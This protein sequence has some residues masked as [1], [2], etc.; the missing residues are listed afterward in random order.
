MK[1]RSW[2][3]MLAM[4]AISLGV[5]MVAGAAVQDSA[6]PQ[7]ASDEAAKAYTVA[8][9]LA[10]GA[11][12][13]QPA[14]L[15]STHGIR[16]HLVVAQD[17]SGTHTSLQAA[18][19]ALPPEDNSAKRTVIG[20]V[21]GSYRGQVCLQ[22][23]SP[24]LLVGLGAKASDVRIVASRYAGGSKRPGVDGGNPCLPDLSASSYG[25]FS[26]ATLAIF[27]ND[28][29]LANLTIENDAMNGVK[30]GVGYPVGAGES[31]GAQAVALMTQGDRI[32]LENVELW[33]HQDT[34]YV[35]AI[36]SGANSVSSYRNTGDR[37][38]LHKS[39]IAGDVDFIFGAGTL[40]VDDSTIV[41]RHGRRT[42]GN[43]GHILAPSTPANTALGILVNNSRLVGEAGLRN[44][45]ISLGRAWDTG[46]PSGAWKAGVSPNGQAVVR[47]S[48]L[49]LHV[50]AWAASTSKRPFATSGEAANRFAEWRNVVHG[51]WSRKT[52]AANDGWAAA[53]GGT[54]GGSDALPEHNYTVHN[55]A[56]LLAALAPG[57]FSR[58]IRVVGRIDQ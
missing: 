9:Y 10:Q 54:Q 22:G 27:S 35:R 13:W 28:V 12:A 40:V 14:N 39:L 52:L 25:T 50:G 23:K 19:D 47:D 57:D 30:D 3:S 43:G 7:L 29:Q 44:G 17:G 58:L 16:P 49:G 26:S 55:R 45:S 2:L 48:T 11:T 37:V 18:L 4:G 20:L 8:S 53:E 51:D 32:Q 41:S 15:A 34:L 6:R 24:V 46:V 42:P 36:P 31:G 5:G 21:A 1:F 56:E 38:Y 33:G